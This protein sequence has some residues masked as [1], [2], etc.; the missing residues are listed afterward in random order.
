MANMPMPSQSMQSEQGAQQAEGGS[1]VLDNV[2]QLLGAISKGFMSKPEL[3][4][5]AKRMSVLREQYRQLIQQAQKIAGGQGGGMP[6]GP[7]QMAPSPVLDQSRG[8]PQSPAG[9]Y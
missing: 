5:I 3:G 8:T 1:S 9:N 2:D 6:Q 4:D 7:Q